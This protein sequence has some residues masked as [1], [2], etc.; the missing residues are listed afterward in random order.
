MVAQFV[1]LDLARETCQKFGILPPDFAQKMRRRLQRKFKVKV[2]TQ[3]IDV[4]ANHFADIYRF[5][6]LTLKEC[7]LPHTDEYA[8]LSHVDDQ[9]FMS[10]IQ[11]QFPDEAPEILQE[12]A[13]WVI[14]YEYLR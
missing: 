5:A 6:A 14:Q 3:E 8:S 4:L 1:V 7:I 2:S 10:T 11:A 13:H 9:K 12:I